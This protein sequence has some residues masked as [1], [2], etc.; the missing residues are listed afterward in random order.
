MYKPAAIQL[1]R[2]EVLLISWGKLAD[3]LFHF[4]K[5]KLLLSCGLQFQ[6]AGSLPAGLYYYNFCV[7]LMQTIFQNMVG[8]TL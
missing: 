4:E 3:D 6:T 8:L 1:L 2:Q 5:A 7:K